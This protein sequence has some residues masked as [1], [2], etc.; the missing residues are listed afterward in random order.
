MAARRSRLRS[1]IMGLS[2]ERGDGTKAQSPSIWSQIVKA[3]S[4][5]T[6]LVALAAVP[7]V[8]L[9]LRWRSRRVAESATTVSLMEQI[10]KVHDKGF[11]TGLVVPMAT[12]DTRIIHAGDDAGSPVFIVHVRSPKGASMH[13]KTG[14]NAPKKVPRDAFASF[15][16]L[17]VLDV[18]NT[19]SIVLNKFPLMKYHVVVHSL[20]FRPQPGHMSLSD[21]HATWHC[22]N[23]LDGIGYFNSGPVSG[24][25]QPRRHMQ[26]IPIQSIEDKQGEMTFPPVPVEKLI[27]KFRQ[28]R[29]W[30]YERGKPFTL[31]DFAFQHA[32]SL[33]G[34]DV[35]QMVPSEASELLYR[36]YRA[37]LAEVGLE[38]NDPTQSY[39]MLMTKSWMMVVPRGR[40]KWQGVAF[41][42]MA[43]SGIIVLPVE[44][45]ADFTAAPLSLLRTIGVPTPST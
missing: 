21:M 1:G 41:N 12:D 38:E 36:H 19:H 24:A 42:S 40:E 43:F 7:V 17:K 9:A 27:S 8:I 34:G 6:A 10:V 14:K 25:S 2:P 35:H 30:K 23:E 15:N 20:E 29:D 16:P 13:S 44:K 22:V 5:K 45:L 28:A 39:N 31:E 11:A 18:F 26:V 3:L 32:V 37:L 4:S 33:H